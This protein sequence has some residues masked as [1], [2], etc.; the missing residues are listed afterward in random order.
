MMWVLAILWLSHSLL[1]ATAS[2]SLWLGVQSFTSSWLV[3]SLLSLV[4]GLVS[5]R[6]ENKSDMTAYRVPSPLWQIC[7]FAGRY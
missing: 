4:M 2:F 1:H 3:L 7:V 5:Y 6:M